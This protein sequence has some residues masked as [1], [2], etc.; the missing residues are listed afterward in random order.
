M[1]GRF[2]L[3]ANAD[4]LAVDLHQ[5]YFVPPPPRAPPPA[6]SGATQRQPETGSQR[7]AGTSS[8]GGSAESAEEHPAA[9]AKEHE[10]EWASSEAKGSFRPRYNVAPTT[11]VPVLRRSRQDPDRYELDLLKWGLVP[12]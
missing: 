3:G 8:Q 7:Q 9:A 2:A 10:V 5:Q 4:Q 1:C 6:D 11:K 12:Q